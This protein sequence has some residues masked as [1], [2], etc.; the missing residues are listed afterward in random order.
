MRSGSVGNIIECLCNCH[1]VYCADLHKGDIDRCYLNRRQDLIQPQ[2]LSFN[3]AL[4]TLRYR[5]LCIFSEYS[6][7]IF[8][9]QNVT[10]W[11]GCYTA[12]N[13]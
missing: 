6:E 11:A 10:K 8:G 9:F 4:H 2:R 12:D 5:S 3:A 13:T 1:V 7:D